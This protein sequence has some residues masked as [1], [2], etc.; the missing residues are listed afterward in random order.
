[1]NGVQCTFETTCAWTWEEGLVDGFHVVTG[2]NLTDTNHTGAVAGPTTDLKQSPTGNFKSTL[3]L[4]LFLN[5]KLLQGH[6]L[7]LRLS[8]TTGQRILRSPTFSSTRENCY[9]EVF[10]HEGAMHHGSI[11]IAIEPLRSHEAPWV[12]A[13]IAGNNNRRWEMFQFRL[14]RISKEF[15][16]LFEVVPNGLGANSRGHVS[17]DNL[18]MKNCFP[19]PANE[20]CNLNQIKCHSNKMAV[21]TSTHSICDIRV[22]CD[23]NEDELLN[24]GK[25]PKHFYMQLQCFQLFIC[26][27][28][29][30]WWT[31]R[32]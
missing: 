18:M 26:R 29:P 25:Y 2:A 13:E 11:R 19:D 22:D 32:L 5:D 10:L 23:E 4:V 17:I 6:F 8:T 20:T 24:C 28:N 31:L 3:T 21:C 15:V 9:L 12:P 16:I 1:M 14:G 27:Q 7:H 30:I